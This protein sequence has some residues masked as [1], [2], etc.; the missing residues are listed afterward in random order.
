M[1]AT[2]I[3]GRSS[4]TGSPELDDM[5]A[6]G[7]SLVRD[8]ITPEVIAELKSAVKT[9]FLT[10][11]TTFYGG[12]YQLRSFHAVPEV[13]RILFSEQ[14]AQVIRRHTPSGTVLLTGECD[15]MMNTVSGWH[16]DITDDMRLDPSI[17]GDR[18]FTVYKLAIYLQDQEQTS[19]TAFRVRPGSH[20]C[21]DGS[22]LPEARL[23]TR[24]GDV[25]I[26]DVRLDHAGQPATTGDRILHRLCAALA[27]AFRAD[28]E[29]WFTRLR[30]RLSRLMGG[31]PD[32]L[33]VFL[34]F[35]PDT[36]AT[37]IY[38]AAGRHRH[39][40]PP[41]PLAPESQAALALLGLA[42]IDAL[43]P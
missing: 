22:T 38:E 28:P 29:A 32:R 37:R 40:P 31:T 4:A 23:G 27:R 2:T 3:R 14:I 8:A 20:H 6:R 34:T 36:L 9:H 24:A 10:G 41:A 13:A 19:P 16:K 5:Q 18:E 26:F 7:Y 11:G 35:G 12:K 39:G 30:A 17:F 43:A 15:L 42:M 21:Q 1:S 33:A 25:V